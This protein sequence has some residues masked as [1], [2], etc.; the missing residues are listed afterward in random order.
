MNR[1]WMVSFFFVVRVKIQ[2][3]AY[4]LGHS[5]LAVLTSL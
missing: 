1:G 3:L 5:A 2:E 4:V